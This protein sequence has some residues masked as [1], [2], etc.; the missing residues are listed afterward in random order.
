M[1]P[2]DYG[3][4]SADEWLV[5]FPLPTETERS[6]PAD[7]P[8]AELR[9]ANPLTPET[10]QRALGGTPLLRA[11]TRLSIALAPWASRLS[12]RISV[13]QATMVAGVA[14]VWVFNGGRFGTRQLVAAAVTAGVRFLL[15][16]FGMSLVSNMANRSILREPGSGGI[17]RLPDLSFWPTATLWRYQ[18]LSGASVSVGEKEGR[19]DDD[20]TFDRPSVLLAHS[21]GDQ[22]CCCPAPACA[23]SAASRAGRTQAFLLATSLCLDAFHHFALVFTPLVTLGAVL[24]STSWGIFL[25]LVTI[26]ACLDASIPSHA[27]GPAVANNVPVCDLGRRLQYRAVSHALA[28]LV[29]HCDAM[30]DTGKEDLAGGRVEEFYGELLPRLAAKW[31]SNVS[32]NVLVWVLLVIY[33]CEAV[34][35]VINVV[36]HR[37]RFRVRLTGHLSIFLRQALGSCI[38]ACQIALLV[39]TTFLLLMEL[40]TTSL[41]NGQTS[42]VSVLCTS[43]ARSLKTLAVRAV[44]DPSLR[45]SGVPARLESHAAL[46]LSYADTEAYRARLFGAQVSFAF[47]RTL[48]VTVLTAVLGLWSILRGSGVFVTMESVCP[49]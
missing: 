22:F 37:L 31:K 8:A 15:Y 30:V 46:V 43:A 3:G 33:A 5:L 10:V 9:E 47:V 13:A 39:T 24:W 19:Q 42:D 11:L 21:E 41:F 35:L 12:L 20:H 49:S 48:A 25:G 36:S 17:V 2:T 14:F 29:S 23:G 34:C 38:P 4:L 18:Q 1:P 28:S 27:G 45:T 7:D 32:F 44:R 6:R 26:V 40:L 16:G